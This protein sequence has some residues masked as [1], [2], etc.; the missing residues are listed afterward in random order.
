MLLNLCEFSKE[1]KWSLLY[2]AT[3]DGFGATD[4]HSKCDGIRNTLTIIKTTNE[5]VSE[6]WTSVNGWQKDATSFI[7]SLRNKYNFP[8]KAV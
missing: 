2:Q 1:H 5:D 6:A 4:F 7:F 8:F 3:R